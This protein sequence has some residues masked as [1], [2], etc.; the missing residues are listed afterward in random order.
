MRPRPE[1]YDRWPGEIRALFDTA[2]H[3]EETSDTAAADAAMVHLGGLMK[4]TQDRR[5]ASSAAAALIELRIRIDP[6]YEK[7]VVA[8]VRRETRDGQ[9][10]LEIAVDGVQQ[11][12]SEDERSEAEAFLS[13]L[14]ARMPPKGSA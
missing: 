4:Q 6:A 11:S 5:V 7:E 10:L 14:V 8:R 9:A 12:T 13:E 2:V 3:A 1:Q